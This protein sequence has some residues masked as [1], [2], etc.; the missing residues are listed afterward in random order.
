MSDIATAAILGIVLTLVVQV[1]SDHRTV[2][3]YLE[4]HC[5]LTKR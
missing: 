4:T 5:E 2:M 3:T 1:A